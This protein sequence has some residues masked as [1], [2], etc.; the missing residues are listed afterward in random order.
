MNFFH[1]IFPCA[2]F[3]FVLRPPPP[4]I[5]FL[6]VHPLVRS[7][8]RGKQLQL[9]HYAFEPPWLLK[10]NKIFWV[11]LIVV[12]YNKNWRILYVVHH[13]VEQNLWSTWVYWWRFFLAWIA[14]AILSHQ[15]TGKVHGTNGIWSIVPWIWGISGKV[16]SSA[17]KSSY[18]GVHDVINELIVWFMC[19]E[20]LKALL[21][22]LAFSCI[23]KAKKLK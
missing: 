22:I 13:R 2:K 8:P 17:I 19:F 6:M 23:V 20:A 21:K 16:D 5:G 11:A 7:V 9:S 3:F 18:K 1:F 15:H 14:F 12:I 4:P 10:S